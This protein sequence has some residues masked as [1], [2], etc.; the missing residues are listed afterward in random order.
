[1][2]VDLKNVNPLV[3]VRAVVSLVAAV[4]L[5]LGYYDMHLVPLSENDIA[6]IVNALFVLSALGV[7]VWGWW[8]NNSI[9]VNA[10]KADEFLEKLNS[11]EEAVSE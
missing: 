10:Q 2:K 11:V 6:E 9:T 8:K 5:V 4:N 7:W 1:M 3:V